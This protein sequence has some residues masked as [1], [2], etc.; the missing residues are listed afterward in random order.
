MMTRSVGL[1]ALFALTAGAA[2]AQ[3]PA[4]LILHNGKIA[5]VD[6][7]FSI[8]QAIVVKDGKVVAVGGNDLQRS[9]VRRAW[10]ICAAAW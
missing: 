6:E 7:E 10:S 4:D 3:Q 5:V 8:H 9:T 2:L 1:A